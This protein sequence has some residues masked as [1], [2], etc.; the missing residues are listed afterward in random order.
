[1]DDK[2][3]SFIGLW[4]IALVLGMPIYSADVLAGITVTKNTGKAGIDNFIDGNGDTWKVE[5]LVSPAPTDAKDV[6]VIVN[7]ADTKEF[8]SCTAGVSG[9]N[10][11]YER[12][13]SDGGLEGSYDFVVKHEYVD[14]GGDSHSDSSINYK[15]FADGSGPDIEFNGVKQQEDGK[16]FIDFEVKEDDSTDVGLKEVQVIDGTGKILAKFDKDLKKTF[17]YSADS[18]NG[19]LLGVIFTG[20]DL[21]K[22]RIKATDL[23][24]HSTLSSYRELFVDYVAPKVS[25][26]EFTK[27][28]KFISDKTEITDMVVEFTEKSGLKLSS[29]QASSDS[30][31][32]TI[33]TTCV[34]KE[35][36]LY[37]CTWKNLQIKP[38]ASIPVTVTATDNYGNKVTEIVPNTFVTDTVA[39]TVT[40]FGTALQFDQKYYVKEGENE[41]KLDVS[42][43]GSGID[44]DGVRLNL[45]AFGGSVSAKATKCTD[46]DD[47][48]SCVWKFSSSFKSGKFPVPISKLEDKLGNS[49]LLKEITL[50]ADTKEPIVSEISMFAGENDYFSIGDKPVINIKVGES[51]G[52]IFLVDVTEVYSN[53]AVLYPSSDGVKDGIAVFDQTNCVEDGSVFDCTLTLKEL[54]GTFRDAQFSLT[55][56]DTAGNEAELKKAKVTNLKVKST[57]LYGFEVLGVSDEVE[58]DFW[59]FV[60]ANPSV[61]FVDIEA[62]ILAAQRI[63]FD[64]KIDRRKGN[65]RGLKTELVASSCKGVG[66]NAS[67]APDIKRAVLYGGEVGTT[68]GVTSFEPKLVLELVEF[69]AVEHFDVN[70]TDGEFDK[71][72]AEYECDFN[73]YSRLLGE[74]DK[75]VITPEVETVK[76]KVPFSFT[77]LGAQDANLQQKIDEA[78]EEVTS[79]YYGT[80]GFL[81][82]ILSYAKLICRLVNLGGFIK[83]MYDAFTGSSESLRATQ[84]GAPAAIATCAANEKAKKSFWT[85]GVWKKLRQFCDIATCRT[86]LFDTETFGGG[87]LEDF[88]KSVKGV[89][90]FGS[91]YLAAHVDPQS[92]LIM[93]IATLC[94]PGIVY[95]LEKGRQI[96]C[97]HISCMENMI[98][99]GQASLESCNEL[100]EVMQCKYY[101]GSI[102][103]AFGIT[104]FWD[105]GLGVIKR[106]IQDPKEWFDFGATVLCTGFCPTSNV[107]TS[108]CSGAAW[109]SALYDLAGQAIAVFAEYK[110]I[111]QDYCSEVLGTGIT[112]F[113]IYGA[114]QSL[115]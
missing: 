43:Q 9:S 22:I 18:G 91:D 23:L 61:K 97:L 42:E 48:I 73:I 4:I 11:V 5:A 99:A 92:N 17:D 74:D 59:E 27:L 55:V 76:L 58:P 110:S 29:V 57:G 115:T 19:N 78:R 45:A 21:K 10:C 15:L 12:T 87:A 68:T 2:I 90:S 86:T 80:I 103:Y 1:M 50:H 60:S 16:I 40:F 79:G 106:F 24:G 88:S 51:N 69:D 20:D 33:A 3:R 65:V 54:A 44:E 105:Y 64:I 114:P 13:L 70:S 94:L 108:L 85:E 39:P 84:F 14:S 71:A 38:A 75:L 98:P 63:P 30:F 112:E 6:K 37:L 83:T 26:L 89:S 62:T 8:Q 34:K 102:F 96:Q 28:G 109:L 25:K 32:K 111:N 56:M 67:T 41:I 35:K 49:G 82:S 72:V 81:N 31:D 101:I 100:R 36:D 66:D 46:T 107:A 113:G 7:G 53:A 93:S 52:L 104:K 77:A 47:G 95:N